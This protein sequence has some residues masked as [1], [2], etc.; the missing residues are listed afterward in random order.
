MI[1]MIEGATALSLAVIGDQ[2]TYAMSKSDMMEVLVTASELDRMVRTLGPAAKT[3]QDRA[4][5]VRAHDLVG[6]VLSDLQ[7]EMSR[8]LADRR[9]D[10]RLRQVYSASDAA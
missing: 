4:A 5:L 6:R 3:E 7:A 10:T 2:L 8:D 1:Q 9:R